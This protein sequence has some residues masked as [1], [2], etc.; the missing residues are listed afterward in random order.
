[1]MVNIFWENLKRLKG[2]HCSKKI[3][4]SKEN[5]RYFWLEFLLSAFID[6]IN[7]L[8]KFQENRWSRSP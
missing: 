2:P 1:M 8:E 6:I 4:S 7:M 5:C 3:A